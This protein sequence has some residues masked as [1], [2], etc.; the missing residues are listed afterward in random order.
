MSY[1]RI[2]VI[3]PTKHFSVASKRFLEAQDAVEAVKVV[4]ASAMLHVTNS[5]NPNILLVDINNIYE[6]TLLQQFCLINK[7]IIPDIFII[8]LTL[9]PECNNDR[10]LN[11]KLSVNACVSRQNFAVEMLLLLEQGVT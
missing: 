2:L 9:Y 6:E 4:A 1:Y 5:F 3:D 10:T 8:A 7:G 11:E